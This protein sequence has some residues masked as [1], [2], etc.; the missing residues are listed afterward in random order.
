[1]DIDTVI[2][3][4]DVAYHLNHRKNGKPLFDFRAVQAAST[5][6]SLQNK[7]VGLDMQVV[8]MR[9]GIRHY[10]Y[11]RVWGERRIISVCENSLPLFL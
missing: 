5:T 8:S 4:I 6:L 9:E 1:V 2:Q 7:A 11:E 3:A 10:D